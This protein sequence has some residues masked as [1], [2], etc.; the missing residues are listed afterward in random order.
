[1]REKSGLAPPFMFT[2]RAIFEAAM[3]FISTCL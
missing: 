3:S 2:A 1:M